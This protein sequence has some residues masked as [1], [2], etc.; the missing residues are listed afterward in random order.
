MKCRYL[1]RYMYKSAV[2]VNLLIPIL[3]Y[4]YSLCTPLCKPAQITTLRG[5]SSCMGLTLFQSRVK[6]C[7]DRATPSYRRFDTLAKSP[8]PPWIAPSGP[9]P[10]V[11]SPLHNLARAS[12]S[13]RL[14][15]S[16]SCNSCCA[17]ASPHAASVFDCLCEGV[18]RRAGRCELCH[19]GRFVATAML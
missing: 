18:K 12:R 11:S 19:D 10:A 7:S 4:I 15:R 14:T 13:L 8:A 6:A 2:T 17:T 16:R 9:Q 3:T 1:G 5:L